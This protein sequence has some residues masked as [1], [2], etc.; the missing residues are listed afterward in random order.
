MVF[1]GKGHSCSHLQR[2]CQVSKHLTHYLP[3]PGSVLVLRDGD[4]GSSETPALL[5]GLSCFVEAALLWL[6]K[7]E[8]EINRGNG[9][10]VHR[11]PHLRCLDVCQR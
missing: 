11:A 2:I 4:R 6:Q 10:E 1:K 9:W 8:A 5:S 7:K 3:E